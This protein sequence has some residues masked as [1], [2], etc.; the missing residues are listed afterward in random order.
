MA[1]KKISQLTPKGSA[2]A[3]TDL[4][5][6]SVFNGVTYDTKSLTGA[7][8]VSG[9]Q[10]TLFS[11]TNI[12]TINSTSLLGSGNIA[13]STGLTVGTTPI[14]SGTDTRLLYQSSGV[15]SQ[16]ANLT[17]NGTALSVNNGSVIGTMN[18]NSFVSNDNLTLAS[19]PGS[20]LIQS[21]LNSTI[22]FVHS[23]LTTANISRYGLAIGFGATYSSA[24]I[25][26]KSAGALSTDIAFRVRNSADTV[27]ILKVQGDA[28]IV[29]NGRFGLNTA[30]N[31]AIDLFI[32]AG[33]ASSYGIY[34]IGTYGVAA[35]S[36]RPDTATTNYNFHASACARFGAYY[37]SNTGGGTT[38]TGIRIGYVA[39]SFNANT[40]DNI[41]FKC[42]I[43]NSGG[44]GSIA[45]DIV[46]GNFRFGTGTGTKIATATTQKIGFW[47]AT[48]IVQPTT[49]VAAATVV[50]GSGGNVKHDDTFDG[51]TV[52][53]VVRALRNTG[54]LA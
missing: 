12:K 54:L 50:S 5:E 32:N 41:G 30:T 51:Y 22:R 52:E 39:E 45:L 26:V 35:I 11:G 38:V 48:P 13:I 31:S 21:Q 25:D 18:S 2:L 8:V 7:N 10:P 36:A 23:P 42:D 9:L 28:G 6:V 37:A 46:N 33:S 17:F 3:G 19:T 14:T 40:F 24:L 47:N 15:L 20:V 16:S 43:A 29:H 53:Q 4:L 1:N 27:D 49:A 34:A 44:G